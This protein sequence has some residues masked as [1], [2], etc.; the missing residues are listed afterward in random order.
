MKELLSWTLH[1]FWFKNSSKWKT[2]C[3]HYSRVVNEHG[4]HGDSHL[5]PRGCFSAG[6]W[7]TT[8]KRVIQTVRKR[9]T[10]SE[11][12]FPVHLFEKVSYY[13]I[14]I[15][16]I[17]IYVA[18]LAL[19]IYGQS[20]AVKNNSITLLYNGHFYQGIMYG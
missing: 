7:G 1:I 20:I 6:E 2:H 17:F 12:A 16:I 19:C 18:I 10:E 13:R 3:L 14:K 9:L 8:E 11:S 4:C 15:N 5:R